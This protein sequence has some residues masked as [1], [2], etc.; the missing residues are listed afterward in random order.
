[1]DTNDWVKNLQPAAGSKRPS[2]SPDAGYREVK[3]PRRL[4]REENADD[5]NLD[6]ELPLPIY[7]LSQQSVYY[8]YSNQY[9]EVPLPFYDLSQQSVYYSYS[10]QYNHGAGNQ[11][12]NFTPSE[13]VNA[14]PE[15]M[16]MPHQ[17]LTDYFYRPLTQTDVSMEN[18]FF[19]A[20]KTS[21]R[22]FEE[23]PSL[24]KFNSLGELQ[25][26]ISEGHTAAA[27]SIPH[28][29]DASQHDQPEFNKFQISDM[30][31]QTPGETALDES[32][33]V[34]SNYDTCFGV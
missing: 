12:D 22:S 6:D 24:E 34:C 7:G 4:S 21:T 20:N 31:P 2:S 32:I 30:L 29:V 28:R 1:M 13:A 14:S 18:S 9:N 15:L 27:P 26:G 25:E 5:N 3:L 23:M 19:S 16:A 17:I 11:F 33:D 10:N 8:S